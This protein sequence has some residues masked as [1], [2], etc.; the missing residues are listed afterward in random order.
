VP[1]RILKESLTLFYNPQIF[2]QT[3]MSVLFPSIQLY[4]CAGFGD[5]SQ[6]CPLELFFSPFEKLFL[7]LFMPLYDQKTTKTTPKIAKK[8]YLV[9]NIIAMSI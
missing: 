8:N 2:Q 3:I 4:N 6:N 7:K 9:F 1:H 5:A